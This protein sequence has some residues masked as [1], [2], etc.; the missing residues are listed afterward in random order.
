M[1][2]AGAESVVVSRARRCGAAFGAD[3][4]LV[5]FSKGRDA[6][7]EADG[8]EG[9]QSAAVLGRGGRCG[10]ELREVVVGGGI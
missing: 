7:R 9:E 3:E 8:G 4:A 6:A 10:S 5:T 1:E 2:R